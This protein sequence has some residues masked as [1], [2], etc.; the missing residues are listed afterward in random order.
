MGLQFVC[1]RDYLPR[2]DLDGWREKARAAVT[3]HGPDEHARHG[4]VDENLGKVEQRL[5]L[6]GVNEHQGCEDENVDNEADQLLGRDRGALG[7]GIDQGVITWENGG[8][9]NIGS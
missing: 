6:G 4:D 2:V 5:E 8:Q 7:Q 1:I 9:D 3:G